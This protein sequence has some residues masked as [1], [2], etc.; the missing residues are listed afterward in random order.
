MTMGWSQ[1]IALIIS[2]KAAEGAFPLIA[3]GFLQSCNRELFLSRIAKGIFFSLSC[4]EAFS[5]DPRIGFDSEKSLSHP[6]FLAKKKRGKNLEL[7]SAGIS[8]TSI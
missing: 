1:S 8:F 3:E 4:D 7:R 6:A 5:R 2:R